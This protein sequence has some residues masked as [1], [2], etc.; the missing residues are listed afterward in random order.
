MLEY[1]L[2]LLKITAQGAYNKIQ[3]QDLSVISQPNFQAFKLYFT[4]FFTQLDNV[5]QWAKILV[6]AL[7]SIQF[8][9]FLTS[10]YWLVQFVQFF[11]CFSLVTV[12]GQSSCDS[13][14]LRL[15][16]RIIQ[17]SLVTISLQTSYG[18]GILNKDYRI[19]LQGLLM[20][21]RRFASLGHHLGPVVQSIVSLTSSLRGQLIKCFM[22]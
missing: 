9:S 22:T 15:D 20:N 19:I 17:G 16:E 13:V 7:N 2:S 5:G 21:H 4:L 3:T 6:N 1:N 14:I 10:S 18:S 12:N 8:S 11:L